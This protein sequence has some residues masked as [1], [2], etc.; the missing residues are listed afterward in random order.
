MIPAGWA[1]LVVAI[2]GVAMFDVS[3]PFVD[4]YNLLYR[5]SAASWHET[6]ANA[7]ASSVEYRPLLFIGV[8]LAH[9]LA[10]VR[11]WVY[12]LLVILQFAALLVC[13]LLLFKP[14]TRSRA[15]AACV[16]LACATGLHS[17]RVMFML[18]PINAHSLGAVLLL[19]AMLLALAPRSWTREIAFFPLI[20]VALLL[21]ESGILI[22]AVIVT[23]WAVGAPGASRRAVVA[24]VLGAAVY[25]A[26]RLGAGEQSA[27]STYT[28]TGLG[29]SDVS[30]ARLDEIFR[31]AP[32][33]LWLYNVTA[34]LLTVVASEPRAGKFHLIE[35]ILHGRVPG[36]MYIHVLSSLVTTGVVLYALATSRIVQARDRQLA[37]AGATILVAGSAL[38]FLYTRDRIALSAGIGYA[39]L[40]YVA[41][42]VLLDGEPRDASRTLMRRALVAAA[43]PII[44]AGWFIRTGEA[45]FQLRDAAWENRLEWTARYEELGG[46]SRPQTDLLALLRNE[47]IAQAPAD[48]RRDAAWTYVLF[49]REF[50]RL[51]PP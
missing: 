13:L 7:F 21:L 49:E 31:Q 6:I 37:A 1:V 35:F 9:Q 18:L 3:W 29:F 25:L 47:A 12:Q 51:P 34:S 38:G 42:A 40:V 4:L 17:S 24:T 28:E 50:E 41:L 45:Y 8:K 10:G 11:L 16:G 39:L 5:A 23:L 48:P 20:V 32:W 26:V 30:A 33:L 36:W 2:L 46:Y 27:V 15:V 19:G 44:A 43:V 14:D 22:V